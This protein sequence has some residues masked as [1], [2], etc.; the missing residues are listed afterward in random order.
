MH[1]AEWHLVR[2]GQLQLFGS[3]RTITGDPFIF[4]PLFR[5]RFISAFRDSRT[6]KHLY[7]QL[8]AGEVEYPRIILYLLARIPGRVLARLKT[9]TNSRA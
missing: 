2:R 8:L 6:M 3:Q 1:E 9:S 7:M 5:Q 4:L